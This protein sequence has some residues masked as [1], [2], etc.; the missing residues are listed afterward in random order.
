MG[1]DGYIKTMMLTILVRFD[2]NNVKTLM[3]ENR[4]FKRK[5]REELEIRKKYLRG[6][7]TT[8]TTK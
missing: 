1:L 8:T 4:K 6:K 3:V 5:V 2:W 7:T